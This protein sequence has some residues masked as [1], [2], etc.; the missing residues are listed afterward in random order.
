MKIAITKI[1]FLWIT[2]QYVNAQTDTI[3]P[4]IT[5]RGDPAANTC[6][7]YEYIDVGA[8]ISDNYDSLHHLTIVTEGTFENTNLQGI[9]NLRYKVTD[10]AG[11][12]GYSPYRYIYVRNP[13]EF[14]CSYDN[15]WPDDTTKTN[16][17]NLIT[18]VGKLLIYPNPAQNEILIE[19]TE[20]VSSISIYHM[21][22]KLLQQNN[23]NQPLNIPY[24]INTKHFSPGLYMLKVEAAKGT[25]HKKI[26]I[27]R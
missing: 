4:V 24:K 22:G 17:I 16:D 11:N 25:F 7:F 20:H 12:I 5:L 19:T 27:I 8:E 13:N 14:P 18:F 15:P 21:S 10:R 9:F 1:L 23:I 3:A 26:Q 6:Q 2:L